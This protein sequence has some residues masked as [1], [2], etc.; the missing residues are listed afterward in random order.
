MR[1]STLTFLFFTYIFTSQALAQSE[2]DNG[3]TE[4]QF[5]SVLNVFYQV[6]TPIVEA[7]GGVFEIDADWSDGT[8][9]A[10]AW[11]ER[12]IYRVEVP[13]GLAR[14]S[15]M[16][17]DA[18][19]AMICHE[20]GHLLGGEPLSGEISFEGQSDYYSTN[21]CMK[22]MMPLI[23]LNSPESTNEVKAHC[24][25]DRIC[26]RSLMAALAIGRFD[27]KIAHVSPPQL[28]T[29]DTSKVSKT[30]QSH[31]APQCRLD[32]RKAGA[33]DQ[34]RPACWYKANLN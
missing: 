10:F 6:Y 21:V 29:P 23:P 28:S 32:T 27:A 26:E 22:L 34:E 1:R 5:N 11:R 4:A 14:Y 2:W 16:T 18:Y 25:S 13:G 7:Q 20:I 30:L 15:L 19:I 8:V 3:Y 17:E 9:N 24:Q 12:N 33:L 31:P